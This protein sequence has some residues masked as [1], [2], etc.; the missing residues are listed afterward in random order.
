MDRLVIAPPVSR[1][2]PPRKGP[3]ARARLGAG[4]GAA[5]LLALIVFLVLFRWNW[6]RG[7]L[8]HTISARI[9]RPVTITGNLEVHPWSWSPRATING[10][11]IGNA[12][13]AGPDPLAI[14]P[15]L[16][17]QVKILPLL[18]GR[19]VLPLVEADQPRA[20]LAR[21]AL[22]RANW[23]FNPKAPPRPLKLPVINNLVIR[24]GALTY[25]DAQRKLAFSATV[26]SSEQVADHGRGFF[27]LVGRGDLN[28]EPFSADVRGD[29]LIGV[30]PGRPYAFDAHVAAGATRA[31]LAGHIDHPFDLGVL[32]GKVSLSGPDLADVYALTGLALPNTPPYSLTA[33]VA[34]RGT[35]ISLARI[36][37]RVGRSDLEGSL[38]VDDSNHRPFVRADLA[39]RRLRLIDLAPLIGGAPKAGA[40][41]ALSPM[42]K[43]ESARLKAEHRVLPDARLDVGRVRGMDADV[44][45]RAAS[46]EAGHFPVTALR[47]DVTL[48]HGVLTADPLDLT[49]PQGR[50]AGTMRLDAR[51]ATPADAIDLRLTNARLETLVGKPG[52]VP[53][54]SGGLYARVRLSGRGESVRAVAAD[55]DGAVSAVVPSGEMRQAFAELLG[56]DVAKGLLLIVGKSQARTPI[57][58]AV[59]DFGARNGVLTARTLVLDTGVV[60][61]AGSGDI[62]LRNEGVALRL[63]GSPKKFRLLRLGAPITISGDLAGP[64][65]GVDVLKAAPQAAASVAVGVLAAPLAAVLPFVS[66]G[67][68]RDADCGALLAREQAEGT[69]LKAPAK[70][71]IAPAPR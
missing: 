45:Y 41:E 51:G 37:G 26:S 58:C 62:D 42:E 1:S 16:T 5:V 7:P 20:A 69:A 24:G 21:D 14:L 34:R 25:H 44:R 43:V 27:A 50:L 70:P 3:S 39:S 8:A 2:P 35:H 6:L 71:G 56:I 13:W 52:A 55:A 38:S 11:V 22:G 17:V 64:R 23:V 10:L 53:P 15:R 30:D 66:P 54:L 57:R 4:I 65:V 18:T 67:L 49:L 40:G 61:V 46:V 28:G 31:A 33:A 36:D 9:H 19:V 68:A 59:A 63:A 48:D 12:P 32:E 47:L 60:R 29:P